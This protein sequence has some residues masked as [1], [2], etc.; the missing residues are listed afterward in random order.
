MRIKRNG[1]ARIV[2]DEVI[3]YFHLPLNTFDDTVGEPIG[4]FES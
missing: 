4:Y 2:G 3:H 1:V